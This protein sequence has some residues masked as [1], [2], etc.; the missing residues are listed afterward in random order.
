MPRKNRKMEND[1]MD[2]VQGAGSHGDM[3]AGDEGV[4]D[5]AMSRS[6]RDDMS[7]TPMHGDQLG[8]GRTDMNQDQGSGNRMQSQRSR[9]T[10]QRANDERYDSAEGF[11]GQGAQKEGAMDEA[12]GTGYTDGSTTDRNRSENPLS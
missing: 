1:R 12:E 5:P 7:A 11:S 10:N 3:H 8:E 2:R 4:D 9:R 6:H